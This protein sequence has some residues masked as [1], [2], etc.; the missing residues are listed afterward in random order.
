VFPAKSRGWALSSISSLMGAGTT[1]LYVQIVLYRYRCG[2]HSYAWTVVVI[3]NVQ[4]TLTQAFSLIFF[5][6]SE[7]RFRGSG[8]HFRRLSF[9][10]RILGIFL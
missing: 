3:P 10:Q 9:G 7:A 5:D 4:F 6:Y 2:P 1:I 8:D